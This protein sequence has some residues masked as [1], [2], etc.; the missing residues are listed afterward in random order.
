MLDAHAVDD[1]RRLRHNGFN[2]VGKTRFRHPRLPAIPQLPANS[3]QCVKEFAHTQTRV[4]APRDTNTW[5]HMSTD[6]VTPR[7]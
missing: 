1:A 5:H 4:H 6:G 2:D 7:Y 3:Q